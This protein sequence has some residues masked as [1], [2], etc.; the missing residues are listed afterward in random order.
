MASPYERYRGIVRSADQECSNA[1]AAAEA[2]WQGS[3]RSRPAWRKRAQA[4]DEAVAARDARY[5]AAWQ[6]YEQQRADQ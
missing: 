6:A 4:V 3:D 1:C 2:A 5:V